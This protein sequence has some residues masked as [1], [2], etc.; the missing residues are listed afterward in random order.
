MRFFKEHWLGIFLSSVL[1]SI[2]AAYIYDHAKSRSRVDQLEKQ[3][4]ALQ[5]S[6]DPPRGPSVVVI[7]NFGP[8]E[9]NQEFDRLSLSNGCTKEIRVAVHYASSRSGDWTTSGWWALPPRQTVVPSVESY[10]ALVYLFAEGDKSE[11]NG[12]GSEISI[13]RTIFPGSFEYRD[14]STPNLANPRMVSFF[15][16]DTGQQY[17]TISQTLDCN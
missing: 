10:G 16:I 9:R 8:G 2:V 3:A 17:G 12:D 11:W 5:Q 15:G 13:R 7:N 4:P 6:R 14:G 1:A